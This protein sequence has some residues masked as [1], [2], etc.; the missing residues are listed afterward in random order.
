[1]TVSISMY[2]VCVM[3]V[4]RL[5]QQ[6]IGALKASIIYCYCSPEKAFF[7]V[8]LIFINGL[9]VVFFFASPTH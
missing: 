9:L 1:M 7:L 8:I 5:E 6:C 2:T 3:F 4:Q